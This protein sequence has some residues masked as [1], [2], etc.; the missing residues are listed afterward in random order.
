MVRLNRP[1][2]MLYPLEVRESIPELPQL[3]KSQV[4]RQASVRKRDIPRRAAA[5][6]A[7]WKTREMISQSNDL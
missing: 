4:E 6:D 2:Q 7:A 3:L 1:V 5:L